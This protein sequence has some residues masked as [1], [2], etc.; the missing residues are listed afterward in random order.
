MNIR[1][2]K[3]KNKRPISDYIGLS[4]QYLKKLETQNTEILNCI[5]EKMKVETGTAWELLSH[6][7]FIDGLINMTRAEYAAA[8]KSFDI[9]ISVYQKNY[10][11]LCLLESITAYVE[12]G[13]AS[14]IAARID[15]LIAW[16]G[17]EDT[18]VFGDSHAHFCFSGVA[19][20]RVGWMGPVTMHRVG[21]DGSFVFQ[22]AS[23]SLGSERNVVFCFG[24]IDCRA[25]IRKIADRTGMPVEAVIHDVTER[26]GATLK[27]FRA[28]DGRTVF[29][30]GVVPPN[31]HMPAVYPFNSLTDQIALVR[32]FNA[33]LT[34]MCR[35]N[36]F[37]FV[38]LYTP[39]SNADG[40]L[41]REW[42]DEN[43]HLN[44]SL[45]RGVEAQL[46]RA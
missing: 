22:Q 35:A 26:F 9:S 28:L 43:I 6:I 3:S 19:R 41:P 10:Y 39:F 2:V 31:G 4:L 38:D 12:R 23:E 13:D 29:V 27:S 45:Y 20:A 11:S 46:A 42:S 17:N 37:R 34:D 15:E 25:H 36:A 21:R 32:H 5:A 33:A 8:R 18:F 30:C 40:L 7:Y 14:H 44:S 24:E 16:E 1:N